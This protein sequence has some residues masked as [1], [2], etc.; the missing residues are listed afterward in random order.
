M[1][2]R[3][4]AHG[5]ERR[6]EGLA[7]WC[8]VAGALPLL[9]A[10]QELRLAQAA[11]AG[12]HLSRNRL[13]ESNLRLVI[14]VARRFRGRGVAVEDL[15]QEGNL[16]LMKAVEKY[17]YRRG[18][19]F[20]TYATWWIRQ[21]VSRAVMEQ[22]TTIRVPIHVTE[23]AQRVERQ[24]DVNRVAG[25]REEDSDLAMFLGLKPDQ[26][27]RISETARVVTSLDRP[28]REGES[29]SLGD[30]IPAESDE[31]DREEQA[32]R[33]ALLNGVM[34]GLV[35]RDRAILHLRYG[36]D[37]RG[38]MSLEQVAQVFG[39]TRERVRQLELRALRFLRRPEVQEEYRAWMV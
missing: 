33:A 6:D 8:D 37:P 11:S 34:A 31:T 30:A 27:G 18:F 7:Y 10:E 2:S 14:S 38:P 5:Y 25:R 39:L 15:I 13:I 19:R 9:T 16:G 20:S 28:L 26:I 24:R 29:S 12:C 32:V 35:E 36:V 4:S 3:A 21:A 22:G 1:E 17:D 23:L